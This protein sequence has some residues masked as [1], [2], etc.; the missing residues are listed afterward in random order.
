MEESGLRADHAAMVDCRM[1]RLH[2][3]GSGRGA[4]D[5]GRAGGGLLQLLV[6]R[7]LLRVGRDL[8]PDGDIGARKHRQGALPTT[9]R[10][11]L[12]VDQD[13]RSA[14]ERHR[15][16]VGGAGTARHTAPG[17]RRR[18]CLRCLGRPAVRQEA[19]DRLPGEPRLAQGH[20]ALER[21]R[22]KPAGDHAG[23]R[24]LGHQ[25]RHAVAGR[26]PRP[27]GAADRAQGVARSRLR[28]GDRADRLHRSGRSRPQPD[29]R[30]QDPPGQAHGVPPLPV[31]ELHRRDLHPRPLG[32]HHEAGRCLDAAADDR[33]LPGPCQPARLRQPG[34]RHPPHPAYAG[35]GAGAGVHA[36]SRSR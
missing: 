9:Q 17:G 2:V 18:P 31:P 25:E 19:A 3:L 23:R 6:A 13:P 28:P 29:H 7:R 35:A 26:P 33:V 20:R 11:R 14:Y 15:R 24:L 5:R 1:R 10:D 27:P 4:P 21:R 34:Q 12:R 32:R 22:G 30:A 36:P 8:L 16:A